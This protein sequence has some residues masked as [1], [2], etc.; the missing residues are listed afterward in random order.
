MPYSCSSSGDASGFRGCGRT[1]GSLPAFDRHWTPVTAPDDPMRERAVVTLDGTRCASDTEL[2]ARGIDLDRRGVWLD[3]PE[4]DRVLEASAPRARSRLGVGLHRRPQSLT[5][6][7]PQTKGWRP[8]ERGRRP[9]L[10]V[11]GL[12]VSRARNAEGLDA[13]MSY[14]LKLANRNYD[15]TKITRALYSDPYVQAVVH[16][17]GSPSA[18]KL[19]ARLADRALVRREMN[20]ITEWRPDVIAKVSAFRERADARPWPGRCGPRDR[21]VL[22]AAYLSSEIACSDTFRFA[23]RTWAVRTGLP[24]T[25]IREAVKRLESQASRPSSH[26][27]LGQHDACRRVQADADDG[28]PHRWVYPPVR[29]VR[30]IVV[31]A[32]WA[33]GPFDRELLQHDAF[34][35]VALGERGVEMLFGGL[36]RTCR[37]APMNSPPHSAWSG[38]SF[39]G[40]LGVFHAAG[41]AAPSPNGWVRVPQSGTHGLAASRRRATRNGGCAGSATARRTSVRGSSI[42]VRVPNRAWEMAGE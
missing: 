41:I 37:S 24:M 27:S 28:C 38:M 40:A 22:E 33:S 32:R 7:S 20:P 34:R 10:P 23:Y 13:V 26:P 29:P 9:S 5:C 42:G 12:D 4:A 1:F 3:M 2:R 31:P 36:A 6:T 17:E 30:D 16:K 15:H 21:R 18:Q 39:V 14:A 35:P 25:S 8:H 19:V 11:R